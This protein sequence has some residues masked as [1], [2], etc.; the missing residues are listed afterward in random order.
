MKHRLSARSV[1][2]AAVCSVLLP[3]CETVPEPPPPGGPP[4]PAESAAWKTVEVKA[5]QSGHDQGLRDRKEGYRYDEDR[6]SRALDAVPKGRY[7][8]GYRKGYYAPGPV[9]MPIPPQDLPPP[10]AAALPPPGPTPAPVTAAENQ[11]AV[12]DVGFQAGQ[13]D[14]RRDVNADYHRHAGFSPTTE[15]SFRE[16]YLDGYQSRRPAD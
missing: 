1:L 5:Y 3:S 4:M 16:G 9:A 10:G 8:Q 11:R 14:R 6:G 2:A 15:Q 7:R 12:Y 13:A